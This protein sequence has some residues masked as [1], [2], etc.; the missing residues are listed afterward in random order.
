MKRQSTKLPAAIFLVFAY[1][2]LVFAIA[3]DGI[4]GRVTDPQGRSVIGALVRLAREDDAHSTEKL[5]DE[6]GNFAFNELDKGK[7]QLTVEASGFKSVTREVAISSAN[8]P[9]VIEMKFTELAPQAQSIT[10][11]ADVGDSG[12]FSPDP[13]TRVMVRQETLDANPGRPGM[14]VSIPG[15]P[16]ESPAGGI[17]PPQYFV[18][19]VAGDHGEPIAQFF[20][21]GSYLFPNNLPANAHGNGYA[22]PNVLIPLAIESVQTDGG[23][24]NVREGNHAVNGAMVFG[25]R[26]RIAALT[27]ITGDYRDVNLATGWS[28]AIASKREWVGLEFSYGNGFLKRLEHRKQYKINASRTFNLGRHDLTIYGIGYHGFSFLPGL[29]PIETAVPNDTIDNRQFERAGSVIAVAND[30]WHVSSRSELQISGFARTY[31]LQV[32]P[33]FGDGLIRQSEFRTANSE[34]IVYSLNGHGS[35]T[36]LSGFEHRRDAPRKLNLDRYGEERRAFLPVTSNDLTINSVAPFASIDGHLTRLFRY[37]LGLRHDEVLFDNRDRLDPGRSFSVRQEVTSP[38]AT[39]SVV[40]RGSLPSVSLSYGQAFHTNDPRIGITGINDGTVVSKARSSQ[41][42]V[43]QSI[44]KTD[45]KLTLARV[46]VD[47]QLAKI[48]NDTGLQEDVGP[49]LIRSMSIG[50]RRYFSVGSLQAS[51]SRADARDRLTGEPTPEA[52]RLIWDLLGTL[53]RLPWHLQARAE[54]QHVGR[55]PLGDGFIATPV[56]ELRGA[57]IRQF[58]NRSFDVGLNFFIARGYAGQTLETLALPGEGEPFERITGFRLRSYVT[59]S[60]T[61]HFARRT[62]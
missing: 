38:K 32:E 41:L 54:Y 5:S 36:I 33:N 43:R 21:V 25:L 53:D 26:D 31:R 59:A 9:I 28:P 39:I 15:M 17:K 56:K 42:V 34:N 13:A 7:Y 55:K 10:V 12:A 57:I 16:V 62:P 51:F 29:A 20:Q 6:R 44:A 3:N 11:T 19:G 50:A 4:V 61:Y 37:D 18:P 47:Q 1:Q 40:P 49:A 60:W 14:P 58:E 35:F 23:A 2:L 52:P 22:D 27:R 45:L 46:S 48:N 30:V 24:F 8:Q